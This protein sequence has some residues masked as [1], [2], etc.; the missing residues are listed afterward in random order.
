MPYTDSYFSTLT[1]NNWISL[2]EDFP[3]CNEIMYES[4]TYLTTE[5]LVTIYAFV[6]MRDHIHLLWKP[7]SGYEINT[8]VTKLKK[9]TGRRFR[10]YLQSY[11]SD[12]LDQY[13]TSNRKDRNFKFWKTD[14]SN[15]L[16]QHKDIFI[17]KINYIHENPTKG[18]YKI[19][20]NPTE[21]FHSSA[22]SHRIRTSE[23][24]FLTL[25]T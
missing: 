23:F 18:D 10:S 25:V 2:F 17:Q 24:A 21:Y 13:F 19:C 16:I 5:N 4:L 6:I 7:G 8:V 9:F 12:Y 3:R 14:S 1:I 15:F 22:K 11:D 20:D